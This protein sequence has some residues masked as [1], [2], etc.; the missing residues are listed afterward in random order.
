MIYG[1]IQ[2]LEKMVL[3]EKIQAGLAFLKEHDFSKD[4]LGV[5]EIDENSFFVVIEY[6]T[7]EKEKCFWESHKTNL[8][9]HYIIE[10]KE[11]IAIEHI[12]RLVMMEPY[13]TEK[14]AIIFDGEIEST[15]AMNPEDVMICFPEDGHM[16]GIALNNVSK[17]RKIVLK[18]K[19]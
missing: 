12:D 4:S 9:L 18:L 10:G 8:D 13:N 3:E 6:E 7:K 19:V 5:H 15:I 16:T 17:V 1:K 2:D 11:K 14:D